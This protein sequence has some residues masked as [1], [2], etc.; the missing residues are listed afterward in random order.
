MVLA[1]GAVFSSSI[2]PLHALSLGKPMKSLR[3]SFVFLLLFPSACSVLVGQVKPLEEKAANVPSR[4]TPDELPDWVRLEIK[5]SAQSHTDIPDAAWQSRKSS[6]VISLNSVCSKQ[7]RKGKDNLRSVTRSLL[8][9]WDQLKIHSEKERSL[10]SF[11]AL[12]TTA[13]GR[14]LGQDRK[15]QLLIVKSPTCIYDLVYLAPQETYEQELS[16]FQRFHDNLS[17]K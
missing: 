6:A 7:S 9:Q 10:S 8:T 15:F 14:Y 3:S 5:S 1:E 11:P 12:T 13:T 16:V 2:L 4:G 17:L